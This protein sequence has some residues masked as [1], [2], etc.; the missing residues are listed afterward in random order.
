MKFDVLTLFPD[1]ITNACDYSIIK[2]AVDERYI[3]I[4]HLK[5]KIQQ[6][7]DLGFTYGQLGR[8]CECAPSSISSW[9]RG[10]SNISKRM[11]ESIENHLKSFTKILNQIWE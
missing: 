9:M 8:I 5:E 4:E 7:I 6:M 3:E 11:E 1:T 10:A 2:R